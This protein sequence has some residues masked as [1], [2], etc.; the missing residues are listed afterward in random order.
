MTKVT[1]D[2]GKRESSSARWSSL[3]LVQRGPHYHNGGP[4]SLGALKFYDT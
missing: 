1:V 2:D 3:V 4:K